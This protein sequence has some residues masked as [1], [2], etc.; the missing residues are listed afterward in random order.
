MYAK[1]RKS[2]RARGRARSEKLLHKG[3]RRAG[4]QICANCAKEEQNAKIVVYIANNK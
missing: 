4:T 2:G 1:E 3:G